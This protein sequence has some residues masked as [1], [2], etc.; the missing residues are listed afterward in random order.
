MNAEKGILIGGCGFKTWYHWLIE[1]LPK[2]FIAEKLPKKY[3]TYPLILPDICR[4]NKNFKESLIPFNI[5]KKIIYIKENE[6]YM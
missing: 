1:C 2:L 3:S 4:T 5:K 6:L